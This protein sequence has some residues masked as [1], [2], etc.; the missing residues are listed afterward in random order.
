MLLGLKKL[1]PRSMSARSGLAAG[2]GLGR[3]IVDV[4]VA[5]ADGDVSGLGADKAVRAG[6]G[7]GWGVI[8]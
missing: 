7:V 2:G 4:D 5:A 3:P 8:D 1:S 6:A